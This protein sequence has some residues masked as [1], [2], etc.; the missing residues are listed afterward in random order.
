MPMWMQEQGGDPVLADGLG[1]PFQR[2]GG[3][4]KPLD[5]ELELPVQ[6]A[7]LDHPEQGAM[8]AA[9]VE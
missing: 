6:V 3:D 5:R 1:T 2:E 8:G 7:L 4:S 9:V